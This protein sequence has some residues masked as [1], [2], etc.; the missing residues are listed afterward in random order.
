MNLD[1]PEALCF[2]ANVYHT[3]LLH[4]RLVLSPPGSQVND[5]PI[6]ALPVM[7][8]PLIIMSTDYCDLRTELGVVL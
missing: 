4:A 6:T 2:F 8:L 3:L 1:S 7:Y 5:G